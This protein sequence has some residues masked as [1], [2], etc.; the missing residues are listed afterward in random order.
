MDKQEIRNA[1]LETAVSFDTIKER[2]YWEEVKRQRAEI[3]QLKAA[4]LAHRADL[5][6]YSSRPCP[7]CRQSA[8]ALGIKDKVPYCC[9][10]EVWDK[11]H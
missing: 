8:E 9:A 2:A 11:K 4:L 10:K 6:N 1:L 3:E 5:H 7:T